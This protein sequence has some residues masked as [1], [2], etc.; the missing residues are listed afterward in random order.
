[1]DQ[2]AAEVWVLCHYL[3]E[4]QPAPGDASFYLQNNRAGKSSL[5]AIVAG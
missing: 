4:K 1:M 5:L 2:G 3:A